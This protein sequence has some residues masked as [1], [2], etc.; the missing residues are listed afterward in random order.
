MIIIC[1]NVVSWSLW[2]ADTSDEALADAD[3]DSVAVAEVLPVGEVVAAGGVA[4][5]SAQAA[6]V[7]VRTSPAKVAV[8]RLVRVMK[9]APFLADGGR[10][11]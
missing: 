6:R 2:S 5:W 10:R 11:S 3:S 9:D 1:A 4:P 8:I 7:A